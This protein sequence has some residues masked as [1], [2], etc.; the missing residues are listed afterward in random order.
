[1]NRNKQFGENVEG[2]AIPVL[3]NR[4]IRATA[5][6]MFLLAFIS[7]ILM[8][9]ESAFGICLWLLILG[10]KHKSKMQNK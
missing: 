9:S 3:N 6:I 7:L 8:F 4:E 2:Y 1:M 10:T 5:G